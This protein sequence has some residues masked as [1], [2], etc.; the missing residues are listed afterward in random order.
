[1]GGGAAMTDGLKGE[2]AIRS[3]IRRDCGTI[4]GMIARL[5]AETGASPRHRTTPDELETTGFGA[6][7]AWTG[8][9]A[10][11]DG[12]IVGML[13]GSPVFSSWR[14]ARGLFVTDLYVIPALRGQ[15]IARRLIT[16]AAQSL[17]GGPAAF[18]KLEVSPG[19]T[20]ALTYY[21]GLG[22]AVADA[23]RIIVMD[24]LALSALLS[25]EA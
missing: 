2:V 24:G 15:G 17:P 12:V 3:A 6:H 19:N 5:A 14:G 10:V 7:P 20:D 8:W 9:V 25:R 21:A 22:F 16:V 23:D 13:I 11:Q 4:S 18:L 1:M